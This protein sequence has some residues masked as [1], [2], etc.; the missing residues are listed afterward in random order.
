MTLGYHNENFLVDLAMSGLIKKNE[1]NLDLEAL[2]N[3]T[4]SIALN[5]SEINPQTSLQED[6]VQILEVARAY[7]AHEQFNPNSITMD[8]EI[9]RQISENFS[10]E[11]STNTEN[12]EI[13]R[14]ALEKK[15]EINSIGYC[16]IVSTK[17]H[18]K[19]RSFTIN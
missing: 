12:L 18:T 17:A 16:G 1:S 4:K 2:P 7:M 10:K 8:I 6:S 14:Q 19:L 15:T 5:S 9:F 3:L 11:P 13:W